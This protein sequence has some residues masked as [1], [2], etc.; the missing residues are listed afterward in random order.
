MEHSIGLVCIVQFARGSSSLRD[1]L[2]LRGPLTIISVFTKHI[3]AKEGF[4][5][6]ALLFDY[7][8]N[9]S[10]VEGEVNLT[11]RNV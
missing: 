11:Q 10:T 6:M 5:V 9:R 3:L 4:T 8:R 1:L 2:I 7:F